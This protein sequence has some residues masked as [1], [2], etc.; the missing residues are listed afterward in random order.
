MKLI[1]R[2]ISY[3][4]RPM[5]NQLTDKKQTILD[6]AEKLFAQFG[7]DPTS[8]REIADKSDV[9]VAMI[10]Y[11]YGSKEN[12]LKAIIERYGKEVLSRLS[13]VY[14]KAEDP[15]VRLKTIFMVYIDYAFSH[16]EPIVI[17]HREMGLNVRP[18]MQDSI[19]QVYS[20]VESLVEEI[21]Q[22]GQKLNVFRDIDLQLFLFT[23]GG[24]IDH[25]VH[26]LHTMQHLDID[27]AMFGL[28][29]LSDENFKT[30]FEEFIWD[31]MMSYLKK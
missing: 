2:L 12:L 3:I 28:C 31:L 1:N 25:Q 13:V 29:D 11:Y 5:K 10:S 26:Q 27:T 4:Y 14:N 16:P 22:D 24:M 20:H 8:T 15:I 19:H 9:N 23:F 6:V 21:L 7:Y 17:A 30:R 18:E